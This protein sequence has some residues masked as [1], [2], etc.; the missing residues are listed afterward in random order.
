MKAT[1]PSAKADGRTRSHG[2][3]GRRR[4]CRRRILPRSTFFYLDGFADFTAV[5][6]QILSELLRRS[7]E[8]VLALTTDGSGKAVF[9]AAG[10]TLRWLKKETARWNVPMETC[11][12]ETAAQRAPELGRWL[13]G[14]FCRAGGA[15]RKR[16]SAASAAS[17]GFCG[18]GMRICALERPAASGRRLPLP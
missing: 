5:E 1:C 4:S 10:E 2:F 7:P 3:K 17:G 18:K 15:N 14:L 16:R 9:R 11:R 13:E 12:P 6:R 8:V